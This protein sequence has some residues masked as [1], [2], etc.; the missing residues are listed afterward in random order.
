MHEG[1]EQNEEHDKA[2][3]HPHNQRQYECRF[4]VELCRCGGRSSS[5]SSGGGGIVF[6]DAMYSCC[7]PGS[8][9]SGGGGA[10]TSGGTSDG[11]ISEWIVLCV[12]ARRTR[13]DAC[14]VLYTIKS[15]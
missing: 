10:R 3:G 9:T 2:H 14:G 4:L 1:E 7:S 15:K 12:T 6:M 11:W 5:S 8:T 13:R